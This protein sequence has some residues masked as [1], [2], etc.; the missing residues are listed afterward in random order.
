MLKH[1]SVSVSGGVPGSWCSRCLFEPSECL[2][3]DWICLWVSRSLQQ[4]GI[5]FLMQIHHSYS[6]V[7]TSPFSLVYGVSPPSHS[8][9]SCLS[10]VSLTLDMGFSSWLLL[11]LGMEYLPFATCFNAAQLI[12]AYYLFLYLWAFLIFLVY[13]TNCDFTLISR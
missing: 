9:S 10:G 6:L 8:S 2:W 1:S 12:K 7:G 4:S 5:W 3:W 11:I 13:L